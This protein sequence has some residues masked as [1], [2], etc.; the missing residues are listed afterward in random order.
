MKNQ[1]T[2]QKSKL[3]SLNKVKSPSFPKYTTQLLN[4][5]NQ[6]AGATK[7]KIVGK[8]SDLFPQYLNE[9]KICSVEDWEKWYLEKKP[10]ALADAKAKLQ[11]HV[12][13]LKDA[14]QLIDEQM[15]DLW[16]HDLVV[17]KTYNGMYFQKAIIKAIAEK[18]GKPWKLSNAEEESKGID[19]YIGD[20]PVSVKPITYEHMKM[21]QESI[22]VRMITYEI[23]T[24]EIIINY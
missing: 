1:I 10:D 23:K 15:M 3:D 14:I 7:P 2:I 11:I 13:N 12:A 21:L 16:L 4:T 17:T 8:M 19:G 9:S 18:E 20:E 22:K 24:E 6:N 5:A